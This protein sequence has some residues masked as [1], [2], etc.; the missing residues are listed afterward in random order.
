LA[1][2]EEEVLAAIT[3]VQAALEAAPLIQDTDME[4]VLLVKV[5]VEVPP[6]FLGLALVAE[7]LEAL[8][9]MAETLDTGQTIL[10]M[11]E[12]E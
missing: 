10:V 12:M 1:V 5:T 7:A 8:E 3:V 9:K 6:Q 11:A 2:A 4:K